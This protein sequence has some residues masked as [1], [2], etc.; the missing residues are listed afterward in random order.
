MLV[1]DCSVYAS[2][3]IM[4]LIASVNGNKS[5]VLELRTGVYQIG[6]FGSSASFPGYENYPNV[7]VGAYGVCDNITQLLEKCP[8]LEADENRQFTVT[9]TPVWKNAQESSGGWRWHKWGDYIGT[10]DPQHEYL[11]DEEGIDLVYCFHIYEKE[12]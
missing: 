12:N 5:E 10:Q 7:T 1:N 2:D 4:D 6:D 8:E 9:L 11:Y 3:P